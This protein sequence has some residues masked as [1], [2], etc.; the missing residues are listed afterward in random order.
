MQVFELLTRLDPSLTDWSDR[1]WQ[2]TIR[3]YVTIHPDYA[4]ME[5]WY[6]R[7]TADI[8]YDDRRGDFTALLIDHGYLDADEWEDKRPKYFIE[9]KTMTGPLGTPFYMS[10][11][12]YERVS[13]LVIT[14]GI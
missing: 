11:H 4:D 10:K 5:P 8:T 3:R 12:Q 6:G 14:N 13:A 9:V 1:N 2:S 7:E